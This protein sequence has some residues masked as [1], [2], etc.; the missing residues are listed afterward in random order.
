MSFY[1]GPNPQESL[2]S[3]IDR[4]SDYYRQ[5]ARHVAADQKRHQPQPLLT[6]PN[7]LTFLRILLV[8]VFVCLYFLK[9]RL[10]PITAAIVFIAAAITDWLDGFLARKVSN[11]LGHRLQYVSCSVLWGPQIL[12]QGLRDACARVVGSLT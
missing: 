11:V 4:R 12:L 5:A 6:P 1:A 9:A 10:A 3:P 8:P 2:D 7:I